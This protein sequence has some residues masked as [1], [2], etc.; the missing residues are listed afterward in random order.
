MY[1]PKMIIVLLCNFFIVERKMSDIKGI[2]DNMT[3]TSLEHEEEEFW[4]KLIAK[5]LKPIPTQLTSMEEVKKSLR[6]LRNVSLVGLFLVNIM[7]II[8]MYTVK[9]PQLEIYGFDARA[10]QLLF[11]AVYGFIII[12][13]FIGMVCHRGVTLVHYFGR[14][15]LKEAERKDDEESSIAGSINS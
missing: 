4:K 13:Q 11:L 2:L 7:W 9:F 6:N 10:F 15:T 1:C 14:I 3:E 12:L 5:H 8:V